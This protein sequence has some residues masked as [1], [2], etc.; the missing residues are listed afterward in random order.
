MR[1]SLPECFIGRADVRYQRLRLCFEPLRRGAKIHHR[2]RACE[3]PPHRQ[4]L[5]QCDGSRPMVTAICWWRTITAGPAGTSSGSI[6]TTG[7][8]VNA[9]F[10]TGLKN[11]WPSPWWCGAAPAGVGLV[12][13]GRFVLVRGFHGCGPVSQLFKPACREER[14]RY[15]ASIIANAFHA[16]SAWAFRR[17]ST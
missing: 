15:S 17:F 5:Q 2:G 13:I 12:R 10:I 11:Q 4:F 14:A 1:R 3:Q 7:A 6:T 16:V 8:V 9:N